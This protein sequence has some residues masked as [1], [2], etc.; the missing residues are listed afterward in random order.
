MF[1]PFKV[2][3][4]SDSV[5]LAVKTP[6]NAVAASGVVTFTGTPLAHT[7]NVQ[8]SGTVT[9]T[10]APVV[11]ETLVIGTQTFLFKASRGGVGQIAINANNTL[12]AAN[13][14]AAIT[15]DLLTVVATN[16][17]GV[18][19]VTSVAAGTAGNSIILT[20]NATGVA[21]SGSETLENGVDFVDE[22]IMVGA[23]KFTFVT[24]RSGAGSFE[25][26][27][28]ANN[29]TQG[30]NL[31]TALADVSNAAGSNNAGAVTIS[32]AVKGVT[33]N[34]IAL[35]ESATGTAV[36]SVTGGKLDGGVD[37]TPGQLNEVCADA[38]YAYRVVAE[39]TIVDANWTRIATGATF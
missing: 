10:G 5:A 2:V 28:N 12:Q 35:S 14:V 30:N 6:V 22:Y 23:Q 25:V 36:S 33:G 8:A 4:K 16:T 3:P 27:V 26:T 34:N 17:L 15:A 13:I 21:V 37:G 38:N 20:T 32:A 1:S 39:N 19:I 11:D 7:I 9:V 24:A 18:V 29:T 31:V